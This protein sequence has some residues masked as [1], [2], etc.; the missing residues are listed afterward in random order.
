[1]LPTL[2]TELLTFRGGHAPRSNKSTAE[3]AIANLSSPANIPDWI[4]ALEKTRNEPPLVSLAQIAAG[5]MP[6]KLVPAILGLRSLTISRRKPL[7]DA[8]RPQRYD[9]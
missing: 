1:M 2:P 6:D 7:V 8:G 5:K 9:R 4:L 3:G